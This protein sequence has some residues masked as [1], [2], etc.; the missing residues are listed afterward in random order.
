M[1]CRI[2]R[3]VNCWRTPRASPNYFGEDT[4]MARVRQ[5]AEPALGS[6]RTRRPRGQYGTPTFPRRGLPLFGHRL[7]DRRDPRQEKTDKP[8]HEV[9]RDLVLDPLG[10]E[11]TWLEGHEPARTSEAADH[12]HG[13]LD[14][15]DARPDDRL[16]RRRTR[17]HHLRSGPFRPRAVVGIDPRLGRTQ[18]MT[19]GRR[20]APFPSAT[21]SATSTTD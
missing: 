6:G 21:C 2:P 20:S 17:H 14:M 12:Y 4:F 11:R 7:R 19:L 5:G 16:G 9:Y 18:Q 8:L 10:M 13:E 15:D 1:P 3:R